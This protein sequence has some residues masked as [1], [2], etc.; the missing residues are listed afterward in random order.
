MKVFVTG[1]AG[2]I[3]SELVRV[4]VAEAA[5]LSDPKGGGLGH[6]HAGHGASLK[7]GT[8]EHHGPGNRP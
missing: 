8:E 7:P 2:F 1:P 3:G 4:L 5:P 6:D